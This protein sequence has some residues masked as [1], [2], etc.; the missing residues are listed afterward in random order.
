MLLIL[1]IGKKNK[2]RAFFNVGFVDLC[3]ACFWGLVLRNLCKSSVF[4]LK[5]C[6]FFG[7]ADL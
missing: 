4:F 1:H 2:I 6:W 7:A 5:F 3:K